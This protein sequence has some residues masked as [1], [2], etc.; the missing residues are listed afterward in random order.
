MTCSRFF[1]L[2]PVCSLCQVMKLAKC[3]L[4]SFVGLKLHGH[5][6][7]VVGEKR[8]FCLQLHTQQRYRGSFPL[9]AFLLDNHTVLIF[10]ELMN[11]LQVYIRLFGLAKKKNLG[12]LVGCCQAKITILL[13]I[14]LFSPR[15]SE[16][17]FVLFIYSM[18][19][20][21]NCSYENF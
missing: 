6:A 15:V 11:V 2:G 5:F 19:F 16:K 9:R 7:N 10:M 21:N 13:N 20:K 18:I 17:N 1:C 4:F 8:G 14:F 12:S 3:G